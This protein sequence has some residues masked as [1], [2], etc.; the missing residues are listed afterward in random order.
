V[1]NL[2]LDLAMKEKEW[3]LNVLLMIYEHGLENLDPKWQSRYKKAFNQ[4]LEDWDIT[5]PDNMPTINLESITYARKVEGSI[6]SAFL[7]L[8]SE[9]SL[10]R[11]ENNTKE[12]DA[13]ITA[14]VQEHPTPHLKRLVARIPN[15]LE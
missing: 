2:G 10:L 1:L 3:V 14:F 11:K 6:Y 12:A 13:L 9:V 4:V 7:R 15:S 5:L 8:Y